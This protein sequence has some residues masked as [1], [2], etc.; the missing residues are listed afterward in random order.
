ME[1]PT[2]ITQLPALV[3]VEGNRE[4]KKQPEAGE[5]D[6]SGGCGEALFVTSYRILFSV[7]TLKLVG[8]KAA[9][10]F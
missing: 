7:F 9:G 5:D 8:E 4:K 6:G 3:S 2:C 10:Y 1:Q